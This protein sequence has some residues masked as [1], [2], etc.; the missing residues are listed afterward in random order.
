MVAATGKSVLPRLP[1]HDWKKMTSKL[2]PRAVQ[3][4]LAQTSWKSLGG[5]E[6]RVKDIKNVV[7]LRS[8]T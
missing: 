2:H 4:V 5:A 6:N 3:E 8:L 7:K 1:L